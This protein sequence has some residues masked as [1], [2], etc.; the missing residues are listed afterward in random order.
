[1]N[2]SKLERESRVCD[3]TT[4]YHHHN[5]IKL[6]FGRKRNNIFEIYNNSICYGNLQNLYRP[7]GTDY[8]IFLASFSVRP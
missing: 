2:D 8:A 5:T 1:M 6:R 3:V 7:I 4:T